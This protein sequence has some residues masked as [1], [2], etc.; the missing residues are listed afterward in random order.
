MGSREKRI[1]TSL[2]KM[3]ADSNSVPRSISQ[4]GR[5]LYLWSTILLIVYLMSVTKDYFGP[6]GTF[7]VTFFAGVLMG[8]GLY[9]SV[10]AKQ[11]PIIKKYLNKDSLE[12][13]L[14]EIEN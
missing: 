14:K 10:V 9:N 2:L 8:V 4:L 1:I 5:I 13:R 6:L 7:V 11:W 12:K 3:L